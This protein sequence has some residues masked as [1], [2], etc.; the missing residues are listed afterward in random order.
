M[1]VLVFLYGITV[2]HAASNPNASLI[3]V[4]MDIAA[5]VAHAV[6]GQPIVS[7]VTYVRM[8]PAKE[9]SAYL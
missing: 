5:L 8:I 2:N 6:P 9:I 3:T 4:T 1:E 7:T